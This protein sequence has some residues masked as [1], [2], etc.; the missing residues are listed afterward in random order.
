MTCG[1][2]P[3]FVGKVN[4]KKQVSISAHSIKNS[5][6][7]RLRWLTPI[8]LASW[9]A[10]TRRTVV[11]SQPRQIVYQ[12]LSRKKNHHKEGLAEWLKQ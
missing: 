7:T 2:R 6:Q 8:I 11:R 1:K 4:R 9:E 3:F 5:K 12:T 10:E